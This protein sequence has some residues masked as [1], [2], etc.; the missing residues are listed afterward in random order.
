MMN[1]I[2]IISKVMNF[3]DLYSMIEI[4]DI[5]QEKSDPRTEPCGMPYLTEALV[6]TWPLIET[7]RFLSKR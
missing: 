5:Y 7:N 4:V 3:T 6:D 2:S 1:Q